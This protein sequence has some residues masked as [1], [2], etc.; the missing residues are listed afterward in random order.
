MS[1]LFGSLIAYPIA[2]HLEKRS[3]SP[4]VREIGK[5][6]RLPFS[7]QS[8]ISRQRLKDTLD[9]ASSEVPYYRELIRKVG[10]K[11][12]WVLSNPEAMGELPLLTKDIMREEGERMLSRPLAE[13]AHHACKSGGSTGLSCVVY[14]DQVAADYS[15]AVTRYCRQ[16]TGL[17]GHHFALH[18]AC[19]FPDAIEGNW[20][21]REDCKCI[22]MNR[23]NIFFD[24]LDEEGLNEI[25]E[26]LR[27][28]CP[29][30]CHAHPSTFYALAE[31]I[32]RSGGEKFF[33]VFESSG[34]WLTEKARESISEN[35]QCRVIDRY[36]LAE[37]GVMAYELESGK[38]LRFLN[39]EGFAEGVEGNNLEGDE[40]A[41]G[42][43]IT[44]FR[45]RLMPLIR[46]RTG[47]WARPIERSDGVFLTEMTGRIHDIVMIDGTSFPTHHIQDVLDHRIGG[48]KEFQ[49]D[50]RSQIP[51]LRIALETPGT[52]E[53][54][55]VRDAVRSFWPK[56]LD[57]DF[58]SYSEFK[59]VGWRG[60][61]RRV[62]E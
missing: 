3:V 10:F 37:L 56:D 21:S 26:Q 54:A 27:S 40:G 60:K 39:S 50:R 33:E 2:E 22:A 9:F 42:L 4:K 20:P 41:S 46:Y 45:N 48:I 31:H 59:T 38:G 24:K 19:R 55:R 49:V 44:G 43:V 51:V 57:T 7:E 47:D 25:A 18:F 35:L 6:Y 53:E 28:R 15:S 23:Y 12:E 11:T 32:R 52:G 29:Y 1:G 30:L 5:F 8:A 17:K 61:F 34:E 58:V 36:G 13:V 16:S 14:Y 62:I